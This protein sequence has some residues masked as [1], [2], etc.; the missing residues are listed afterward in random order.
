MR[1]QRGED[2]LGQ[3]LE[4]GAGLLLE[5]G[6]A[7]DAQRLR[8]GPQRL[9][10]GGDG[11]VD[12][13]GRPEVDE[14]DRAPARRRDDPGGIVRR[15]PGPPA[16]LGLEVEDVEPGDLDQDGIAGQGRAD[17]VR[18]DPGV[19][20]R[21]PARDLPQLAG[22]L[23]LALGEPGQL[24]GAVLLLAGPGDG[25]RPGGQR[26]A[27][28]AQLA[29]ELGCGGVLG[30]AGQQGALGQRLLGEALAVEGPAGRVLRRRGVVGVGHGQGERTVET[31]YLLGL[32][33][34]Q[35][36]ALGEGRQDVHDVSQAG[37]A[38]AVEGAHRIR[39]LPLLHLEGRQVVQA[40]GHVGV[41]G[42]ELRF[43]DREAAA[44]ERLGLGG[45]ALPL[46][47]ARQVVQALG[48][49]RGGRARASPPGS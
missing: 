35:L 18:L 39:P 38:G 8:V 6:L 14:P 11:G 15:P 22:Q 23:A 2:E 33:E 16:V 12:R 41:V 21:R 37:A 28:V 7:P 34:G 1:Q 25:E 47:Q 45:P 32:E 4:G 26:V 19:V 49:D 17:P 9:T 20:A 36:V 43:S 40:L 42:P 10:G 3:R 48:H 46:V 31:G 30:G 13:R 44:V 27:D 5:V 29:D 24:P